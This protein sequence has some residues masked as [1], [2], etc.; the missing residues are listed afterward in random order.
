M[1]TRFGLRCQCCGRGLVRC[2][3]GDL[4]V[5]GL[6][7][8]VF[9]SLCTRSTRRVATDDREL[10]LILMGIMSCTSLPVAMIWTR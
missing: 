1:R 6:G 9:T 7:G 5:P 2:A 8:P 10:R 3:T 4:L